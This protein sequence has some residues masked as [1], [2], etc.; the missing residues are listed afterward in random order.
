MK[1][2]EIIKYL[3]LLGKHE[4]YGVAIKLWLENEMEKRKDINKV[5]TPEELFDN[6]SAIKFIKKMLSIIT[7][8][9]SIPKDKIK[10]N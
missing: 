10:Y 2:E 3:G 8:E 1:Q 5:E 4:Q 9:T 6:K 7:N